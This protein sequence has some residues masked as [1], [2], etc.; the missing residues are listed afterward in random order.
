MGT[1]SLRA[2]PGSGRAC[3]VFRLTASRGSMSSHRGHSEDISVSAPSSP[4]SPSASEPSASVSASASQSAPPSPASAVVP[5]PGS[6]S[7]ASALLSL[8]SHAWPQTDPCCICTLQ[9]GCQARHSQSDKHGAVQQRT[10][11]H[12]SAVLLRLR[13]Y[14]TSAGCHRADQLCDSGG[15][16]A[17]ASAAASRKGASKH[18]F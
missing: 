2:K 12:S 14:S 10:W 18:P 4:S 16:C 9:L 5:S 13:H 15:S 1:T 3:L 8:R 17:L 11:Q 7:S 6:C